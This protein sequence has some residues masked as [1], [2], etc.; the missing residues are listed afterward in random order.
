MYK[1]FRNFL[2]RDKRGFLQKNLLLNIQKKT[3]FKI[4]ESFFSYCSKPNVVRGIYMQTG[5]GIE[6]KLLTLIEGKLTWLIVDMRK[7][8]KNFLKNYRIKLK[9]FETVYIPEGY[10]HGSISQSKSLVHIFAN[11]KYNNKNS[12]NVNWKDTYLNIKWPIKKNIKITISKSHN[13]Y[14]FLKEIKYFKNIKLKIKK[15]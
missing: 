7:S 13:N 5:K 12:I 6:A 10:A 9:K 8:S 3:G 2:L 4:V 1:I 14:K 15:T 11:K